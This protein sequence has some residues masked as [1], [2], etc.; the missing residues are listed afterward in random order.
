MSEFPKNARM[1]IRMSKANQDLLEFG[2]P[3]IKSLWV[4]VWFS[5]VAI[6]FYLDFVLSGPNE[7]VVFH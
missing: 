1:L 6:V 3:V 7:C 4:W 2:K 5:S